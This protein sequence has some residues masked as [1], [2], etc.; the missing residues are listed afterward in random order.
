M[1]EGLIHARL[2]TL[3]SIPLSCEVPRQG[4]RVPARRQYFKS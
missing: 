4:Y 2:Q 3:I 1:H